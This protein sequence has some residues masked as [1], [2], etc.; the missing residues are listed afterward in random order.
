MRS[1]AGLAPISC[2]NR[3]VI[4]HMP[5]TAKAKAAMAAASLTCEASGQAS[6]PVATSAS[7]A[8]MSRAVGASTP[9]HFGPAVN[10]KPAKNRGR[11]P[12]VISVACTT[13]GEIS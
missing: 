8:R 9:S 11:K 7:G 2:Q 13:D 3:Q 5:A 10:R 4:Q 12:K 6:Q 1:G